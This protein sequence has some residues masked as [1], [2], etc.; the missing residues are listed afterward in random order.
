MNGRAAS[1]G[2]TM[3]RDVE[4]GD[5]PAFFEHQRD[6][7]A[8]TMAG[9]PGR[10][11]DAFMSHWRRDVLGSGANQ[12]RTILVDDVVAGYVASWEQDGRRLIAYWVGREFWGRGIACLALDEFLRTHERHRPV[13][14]FVALTNAR[15]MRVL[16]K[17]GFHRVG[18]PI[19]GPDDAGE[20]LFRFDGAG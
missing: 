11:W 14:A 18:E 19:E 7:E 1:G 13:H 12:A 9:F 4:E 17:C 2:A 10:E 20:I 6:P 15:S 8:T 16:E 5:L 3:L